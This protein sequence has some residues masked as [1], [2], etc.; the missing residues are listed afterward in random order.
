[1]RPL[2]NLQFRKLREKKQKSLVL[3]CSRQPADNYPQTVVIKYEVVIKTDIIADKQHTSVVAKQIWL[4][5][6]AY[7]IV[8]TKFIFFTCYGIFCT[9]D[10]FLTMPNSSHPSQGRISVNSCCCYYYLGVT[11]ISDIQFVMSKSNKL[12]HT[13]Y[14]RL[15]VTWK[16]L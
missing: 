8:F 13:L 15:Y 12:N 10:P 14:F 3:E 5:S 2:T 4:K 1:M 9:K 7:L 6:V 11:D 16:V